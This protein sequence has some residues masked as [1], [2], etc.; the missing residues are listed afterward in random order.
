MNI[1]KGGWHTYR[2]MGRPGPGGR[3]TRHTCE[4]CLGDYIGDQCPFCSPPVSG[5]DIPEEFERLAAAQREN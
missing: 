4:Q 5:D 1:F 3:R 2:I